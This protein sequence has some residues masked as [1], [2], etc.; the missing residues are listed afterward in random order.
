M[1]DGMK[2]DIA[3][4]EGVL[5]SMGGL[6]HLQIIMVISTVLCE[7]GMETDFEAVT[8]EIL[9]GCGDADKLEVRL[10]S[11][12]MVRKCSVIAMEYM[13]MRLKEVDEGGV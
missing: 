5:M 1:S 9:D 2:R 3:A 8:K 11:L 4:A 13:K 10:R 12:E 6:S 7:I